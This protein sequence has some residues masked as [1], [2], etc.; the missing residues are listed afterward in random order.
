MVCKE[1]TLFL[2]NNLDV[3]ALS[4]K[5]MPGID[6]RIM[7]HRLNVS[8]SFPPVRKK[9]KVFTQER[10]RAIAEKVH[11]LLEASFIK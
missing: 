3:F 11:K 4:H 5:D 1:L 7:V 9:K 2:K 8:L 6:L 10:D